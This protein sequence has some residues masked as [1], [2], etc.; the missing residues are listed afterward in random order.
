MAAITR[1]VVVDDTDPSILFVGNWSREFDQGPSGIASPNDELI[2]GPAYN[3]TS[4]S[5]DIGL[6]L[7]FTFTG[8]DI[9]LYGGINFIPTG[10]FGTCSI[11]NNISSNSTS[12][13]IASGIVGTNNNLLCAFS[14]L[15]DDTHLLNFDLGGIGSYPLAPG[16]NGIPN[17]VWVDRIVYTPSE[18]V[19]LDTVPAVMIFPGDP[20]LEYSAGWETDIYDGALITSV[21]NGSV[22]F[23]FQGT[24]VAYY[25]M[26]L[27]NFSPTIPS[28][29]TYSI[30]GQPPVGFS[31][32]DIQT[33]TMPN[34]TPFFVSGKLMPGQHIVTVVNQGNASD[35]PLGLKYLIVQPSAGFDDTNGTA[36]ATTAPSANS[37]S[38]TKHSSTAR[39]IGVPV[40][41]VVGL[42][43][44]GFLLLFLR[45]RR[46]LRRR[47]PQRW[48]ERFRQ[49]PHRGEFESPDTDL[50][51]ST[52][53]G[54]YTF[55]YAEPK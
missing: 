34:N 5:A 6:S 44:L 40:G 2:H 31:I 39:I 53:Q 11:D 29:A 4:T 26:L 27:N 3:D 48:A 46:Q 23:T 37:G 16:A 9:N 50:K 14:G 12:L 19:V 22:T 28:S 13:M 41:V 49:T 17:R 20:L 52:F 54:P 8:T 24:S 10:T 42:L 51:H 25:G 36:T 33:G 18:S 7:S 21:E 15:S 45:R 43:V 30:D 1:R 38:P 47:T 35:I 55:S 32:V